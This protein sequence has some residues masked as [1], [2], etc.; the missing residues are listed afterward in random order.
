VC[1]HSDDGI[2]LLAI[3][4]KEWWHVQCLGYIEDSVESR[5]NDFNRALSFII[6][7]YGHEKKGMPDNFKSARQ[8]IGLSLP[9][10]PIYLQEL[11]KKI[12]K[13]LRQKLNLWVLLYDTCSGGIRSV[14]PDCDY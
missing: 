7:H 2:S 9:E 11:K 4:E 13:P 5:Q 3:S 6:S 8:Y 12:R 1:T 10:T 14:S